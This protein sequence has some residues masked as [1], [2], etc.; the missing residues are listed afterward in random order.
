MKRLLAILLVG[1]AA[2]VQAQTMMDVGPERSG[3]AVVSPFMTAPLVI[4]SAG[5]SNPSGSATAFLGIAPSGGG[6][7]NGGST[8]AISAYPIPTAGTLSWFTA[9]PTA[10]TAGTMDLNVLYNTAAAGSPGNVHVQ[11]NSGTAAAAVSDAANTITVA[12]PGTTCNSIG[13]QSAGS[14]WTA[15][16]IAM[17]M[18]FKSS[19]GQ[20]APIFSHVSGNISGSANDYIG[21][22]MSSVPSATEAV[23]STIM[24]AAGQIDQLCVI[25]SGV[26]GANTI[27]VTM[28]HDTGTGCSTSTATSLSTT[29][30][31]A[32]TTGQDLNAGHAETFAAGDC[33]SFKFTGT[34]TGLTFNLGARWQPATSNVYPVFSEG[35]TNS[36]TASQARFA[37]LGGTQAALNLSAESTAVSIV[38]GGGF[39]SMTAGGEQILLSTDPGAGATRQFAFRNGSVTG[40]P[41]CTITGS[42]GS[43]VAC[44]NNTTSA[45]AANNLINWTVVNNATVPAATTWWKASMALVTTP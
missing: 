21:L 8:A 43:A 42:G 7:G 25:S 36:I 45:L 29:W 14:G 22:G 39:T 37:S 16:P 9:K 26:A 27:T 2:S 40:N 4:Y 33:A 34:F 17:G 15:V 6:A 23:V 12:A 20:E 28:F 24:P 10:F 44:N 1:W 38:P 19:V 18:I 32:S 3:A 41:S 13:I 5:S 35:T 31:G 30:T 11:M